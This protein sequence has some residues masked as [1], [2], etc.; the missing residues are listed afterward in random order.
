MILPKIYVI[1]LASSDDRRRRI[2]LAMPS[3]LEFY[4]FQAVEGKK[5]PFGCQI[6]DLILRRSSQ[7]DNERLSDGEFGCLVS[8][9]SLMH[10]LID[11]N[12]DQCLIM[13]D[14]ITV[15]S[16]FDQA[17]M[18]VMEQAPADYDVIYLSYNTDMHINVDWPS[19]GSLSLIHDEQSLPTNFK[20][21]TPPILLKLNRA[22]GLPAYVISKAGAKRY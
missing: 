16:N 18:H 21:N 14:D 12:E 17:L 11:S 4:Y 10:R 1:N 19:I 3:A 5:F 13:E 15:P 20:A 9:L 22:W 2:A 6:G 8:H 7:G